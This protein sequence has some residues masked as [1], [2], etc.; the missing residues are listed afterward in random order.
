MAIAD[1]RNVRRLRRDG[2][3][4]EVIDGH[5]VLRKEGGVWRFTV[6]VLCAPGWQKQRSRALYL[7]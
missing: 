3:A 6:T 2:S 7:A 1:A 5:Y 4:I